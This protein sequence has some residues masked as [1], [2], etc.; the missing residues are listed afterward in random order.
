M[1]DRNAYIL[2]A[3]W[4]KHYDLGRILRFRHVT[5]GR[6]VTAYELLTAEQHEYTAY[7]YPPHFDAAQLERIGKAQ[8]ALADQNFPVT[9]P[10]VG[11]QEGGR[12]GM[13]M[14]G[15]Q[16]SHLMIALNPAGQ[17]LLPDQWT[18]PDLS[19]LGL[20]LAWMH[21]LLAELVPWPT[22]PTP[23]T[24]VAEFQS[25][26]AIWGL[27]PE[28]QKKLTLNPDQV[29]H[30]EHRLVQMSATAAS[31]E[32]AAAAM[33]GTG[34]G[35]N[36]KGWVHGDIQPAAILLDH[37]HHIRTIVDWA[38]LHTGESLEDVVDAF[39]HW[40]VATDGTVADD[41]GRA[42][43]EAYRSLRPIKPG[44]WADAVTLWLAR[45]WVDFVA[46]RR[47]LPR[48]Y[49]TYLADPESLAGALQFCDT[50]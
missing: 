32:S 23:P 12:A 34:G 7:L 37:E 49:L 36:T 42:L 29:R 21:S 18:L 10:L 16:G 11:R 1:D 5:R 28:R 47:I 41:R 13:V 44:A 8:E 27:D 25:A 40:C 22:R 17:Y 3:L 14:V 38:L 26:L 24:A 15:P 35:G 33:A 20:R 30:L 4:T 31:G 48:G 6:Q 2:N 50:R 45:R 39:V 43:L 9:A 46:S 19:L